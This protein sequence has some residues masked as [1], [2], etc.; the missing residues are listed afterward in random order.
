MVSGKCA[1]RR[2]AVTARVRLHLSGT[3]SLQRPFSSLNV[4]HEE[5]RDGDQP[6]PYIWGGAFREILDGKAETPLH[7]IHGISSH[8]TTPGT[9]FHRL[10][11][12]PCPHRLANRRTSSGT[13]DKHSTQSFTMRKG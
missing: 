2:S 4:S 10:R 11:C 7:R 12:R 9:K 5:E 1:T 6:G 8:G 13:G 3:V